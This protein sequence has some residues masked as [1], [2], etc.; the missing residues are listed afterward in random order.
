MNYPI[1]GFVETSFS[2]WPGK[3]AAVLFL[4]S[5]N[6]RCLYC[7]NHE[8]VLH[9]EQFPDYPLEI[10]LEKLRGRRGWI[11]GV[12]ISGGEPTIHPWLA[13]L[14]GFLRAAPG[15]APPGAS[16]GIKLDTNGTHPEVLERVIRD[17]LVDY[18]AMDV[19]APLETRS[20]SAVTGV[21]MSPETLGRIQ[22]SVQILLSG[23]VRH[24]FRTTL[25][26][27]FITEAEVFSLARSVRGAERYTLQNLNPQNTLDTRVRKLSPWDEQELRRIQTEVNR[28][29]KNEEPN[30]VPR[31]AG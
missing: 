26:P 13:D 31:V 21:A 27:S 15:V 12:C 20:Y 8:L 28:M 11:D 29:I 7:H 16:L 14:M 10:I 5:C 9:P 2:D 3:V 18:I 17:G 25:A 6:L 22:R 1:K 30:G 4:P 23:N 19:K 24:E